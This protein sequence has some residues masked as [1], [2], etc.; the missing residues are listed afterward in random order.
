MK[1]LSRLPQ[2]PNRRFALGALLLA[3]V[4]VTAVLRRSAG[5]AEPAV[6]IPPPA[7]DL[8]AG[9]ALQT[10]VLAGGCFWGVQA[11]Y[12]HT[13]GV[14]RAVSGYA[15]GAQANAKYELVGSGTT[16][17][18]E[19]VE[20]TYDPGKV[21]FGKILQIFFSVAHDPTQLDR[22]G[23]DYGPQYR[24]AIFVRDAGQKRVAEAYVAQLNAAGVYRQPIVTRLEQL[25][26]FYPAEDYHQDY[27]TIHPNHPYIVYNDRP[28]VENLQGM[29]PDLYRKQPVLVRAAKAPATSTH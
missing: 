26:A 17:H 12:Q 4:A 1:L 11:V 8:P 13:N 15:G 23:P 20:I 10:V 9:G 21:S 14:T 2:S 6:A 3:P 25:P 7:V 19:A 5:A 18:A 27:A 22:Q 28:K 29:F 16:G 24:S